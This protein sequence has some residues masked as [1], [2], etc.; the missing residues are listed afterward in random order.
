[1]CQVNA[2]AEIST[3]HS[4]HIFQPILIKLETKKDIQDTTP[5]AKFGWC[6]TT[7]GGLCREGIFR[8]IYIWLLRTD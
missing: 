8:Y 2:K 6:G 4:S 7:E 1:M 5:Q 3:P